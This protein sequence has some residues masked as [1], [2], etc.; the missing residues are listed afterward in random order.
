MG[1]GISISIKRAAPARLGEGERAVWHRRASR[2]YE[3]LR[4]PAVGLLRRAYGATFGE[5]EIDDI[6]SSAWLGTLRAL[7]RRHT[8][9]G[10]DEI[11]S[12]LLTAVANHASKELRRRKRKPVAPIEAA[13]AVADVAATP[14][15]SAASRESSQL[16]RDLL[17]S[18]PPRRRAV[19]LLRYGWGLEPGEVCGMV[20]GLSPRAYRKEITRGIDELTAKIKLVEEGRWC[21]EREPLLKTYASGLADKEQVLQAEHHLAHCRACHEFVGKLTGHLHDMGGALLLPEALEVIDPHATLVERI[22]GVADRAR[23]AVTGA[24]SRPETADAIGAVTTA[25]GAG[26]AGAGVAAKLAGLGSAGKVALACF[27]GGAAATACI[28]AGVGPIG[29]DDSSDSRQV[30]API[31]QEVD[32]PRPVEP[33]HDD[34]VD[35]AL[36]P[37]SPSP[38]GVGGAESLPAEE[39]VAPKTQPPVAPEAPPA[40]Q[41]WG[42]ESAA[43]PAPSAPPAAPS[44]GG[45]ESTAPAVQE[46]FGP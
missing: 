40:Q 36:T 14:E 25:R 2:L 16:T 8:K 7:E 37:P 29:I 23:E 22:G 39:P 13:G 45:G 26:A 11:R 21:A 17:S 35:V 46:E 20:E 5:D 33:P 19:M 1:S 12:Y 4:R 43:A 9:L 28:A 6:Y 15:D 32:D 38:A 44:S 27:G 30:D 41:E 24:A 42:V 10:D 34:V 31:Q 3:D 18:L